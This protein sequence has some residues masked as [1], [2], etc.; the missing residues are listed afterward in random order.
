MESKDLLLLADRIH[1]SQITGEIQAEGHIR[2]EG[3]G[4]RLRCGRLRMDWNRR[5]GEA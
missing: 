5:I 3:P 2:L 4:L 1:Y